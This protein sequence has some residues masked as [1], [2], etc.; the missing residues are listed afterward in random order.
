MIIIIKTT[1]IILILILRYG[2]KKGRN[3]LEI[4]HVLRMAFHGFGVVMAKSS[5]ILF[6]GVIKYTPLAHHSW[7][8]AK[9]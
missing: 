6:P 7:T 3:S 2:C 9:A 5:R 1:T 8:N 4:D